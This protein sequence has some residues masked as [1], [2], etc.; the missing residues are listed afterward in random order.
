MEDED[1]DEEDEEEEDRV[2]DSESKG[3]EFKSQLEQ[4]KLKKV[5]II[6]HHSPQ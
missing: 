5:S 1:E 3:R 4:K 2:H 6:I